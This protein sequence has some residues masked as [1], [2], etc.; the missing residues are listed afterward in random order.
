[1]S[2]IYILNYHFSFALNQVDSVGDSMG[3]MH[4]NTRK[5]ATDL[6]QKEK[7]LLREELFHLKKCQTEFAALSV[8]STALLI[9]YFSKNE[10]S[11]HDICYLTPLVI[12][13][14]MWSIFSYKVFSANRI[15]A[16]YSILEEIINHD[17]RGLKYIGWENAMTKYKII[18][19]DNIISLGKEAFSTI[20]KEW[21]KNR[22]GGNIFR[23]LVLAFPIRPFGYLESVSI[24]FFLLS[25]LCLLL[26]N[27]FGNVTETTVLPNSAGLMPIDNDSSNIICDYYYALQPIESCGLCN[28]AKETEPRWDLFDYATYF[29]AVFFV[30]LYAI[31]NFMLM[32]CLK[33]GKLS[34]MRQKHIWREILSEKNPIA[35]ILFKN[36]I[37]L[38]KQ[39]KYNMAMKM[40]DK[41]FELNSNKSLD[42]N[43]KKKIIT[44][45]SKCKTQDA[46]DAFKEAEKYANKNDLLL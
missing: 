21:K 25:I 3:L 43:K 19:D 41:A 31:V 44:M 22:I 34:S 36:S 1:M 40:F 15:A 9:G 6:M 45:L 13:L 38:I 32:V 33:H 35:N 46:K 4:I 5:R 37:K 14:P 10:F 39:N 17:T 27:P 8:T 23:G 29:V 16:Y 26:A 20:R 30:L 11:W 18:N 28:T 12:L 24:L 7:E 2:D 42:W